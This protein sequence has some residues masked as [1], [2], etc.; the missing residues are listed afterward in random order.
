MSLVSRCRQVSKRE[1][2]RFIAVSQP[3]A[4][5]FLNAVPRRAWFRVNT[6]VMRISVQRRLGL[7]LTAAELG[8]GG[9]TRHG[10]V[11]DV[12]GDNALNDGHAGCQTRHHDLLVELCAALRSAWGSRLAYEPKGYGAYSDTRPDLSIEG[13][14]TGGG[15]LAGDVKLFDNI[16]SHPEQVAMRS[17]Y[18]AFHR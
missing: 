6:W 5:D 13:A 18:V 7:P 15:I 3:H 14:G 4:G 10:H 1:A 17:C 16:G 2:A 8:S 9:E 11:H 12:M